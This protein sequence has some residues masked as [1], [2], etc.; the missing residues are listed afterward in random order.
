MGWW[1]AFAIFLY[2]ACAALITA[3]VFVPS[4]GVISICAMACLIGGGNIF[5][6]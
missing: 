6:P 4:G 5:S 2:L 1:L 3:E